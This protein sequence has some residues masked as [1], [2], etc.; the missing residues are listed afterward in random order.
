MTNEQID[1]IY[2]DIKAGYKPF[3][4]YGIETR[5]LYKDKEQ[6]QNMNLSWITVSE[7]PFLSPAIMGFKIGDLVHIPDSHHSIGQIKMVWPS[8]N[9]IELVQ[10]FELRGREFG[11]DLSYADKFVVL[12]PA[13]E[14]LEHFKQ[15]RLA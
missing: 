15:L 2:A 1:K 13:E 14:I 5:R 8:T 12:I 9:R 4:Y 3:L 10:S 11:C 7:P 6:V